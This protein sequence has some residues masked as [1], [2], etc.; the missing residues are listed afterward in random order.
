MYEISIDDNTH[1]EVGYAFKTEDE[2]PHVSEEIW[3]K[4]LGSIQIK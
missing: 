2:N 4:I 3:N 1:I